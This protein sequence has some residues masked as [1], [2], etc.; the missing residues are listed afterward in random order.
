MEE[1]TKKKAGRP[2]A[3]IKK[4]TFERL[5][6]LQCTEVEVAAFFGVS[7][8]TV[9]NWCKRTY[10]RDFPEVFREKREAGHISLRRAQ[11]R[12]AQKNAAMAI[13]LGKNYLGQSDRLEVERPEDDVLANFLRRLDDEANTE[14]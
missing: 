5:C 13:F 12:L 6:A 7:V 2:R 4:D 3:E 10:G 14:Q 9:T 1:T 8:D 11:W